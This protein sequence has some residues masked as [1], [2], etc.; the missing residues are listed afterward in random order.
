MIQS[1]KTRISYVSGSPTFT[2]VDRLHPYVNIGGNT[3]LI[4][5]DML[6]TPHTS[7]I[8]SRNSGNSSN[9]SLEISAPGKYSAVAK[10]GNILFV[11]YNTDVADEDVYHCTLD[12]KVN[13]T[14]Y[15]LS[16]EGR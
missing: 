2:L 16:V 7:F 13:A 11:I 1:N 12:G 9:I 5:S 15:T 4:V 14:D 10:A 8:F 3:S 6:I